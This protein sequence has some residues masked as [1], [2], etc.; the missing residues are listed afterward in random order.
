VDSKWDSHLVSGDFPRLV[1]RVGKNEE[2]LGDYP[3][4]RQAADG[5]AN[6]AEENVM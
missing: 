1:L 6:W 4:S 5:L 2:K 3:K